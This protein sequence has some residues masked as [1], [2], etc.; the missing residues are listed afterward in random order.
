MAFER[1]QVDPT[2]AS[3]RAKLRTAGQEFTR[4]LQRANKAVAE[5]VARKAR[6]LYKAHY[7]QRSREGAKS[8]RPLAT[9]TKAQV[10]IGSAKAP[11]GPG[12]NFGS[13]KLKRFAPKA[14]PDRF[15]YRTVED[16]REEIEEIHGEAVDEVMRDAFP[17]RGLFDG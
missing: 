15:L 8:I 6:E 4:R 2:L 14:D 9:Q 5:E 11:Y 3:M 17:E 13:N 7:T 12:Q 16:R 1:I 10:A